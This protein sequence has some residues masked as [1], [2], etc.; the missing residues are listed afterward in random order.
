ML[1]SDIIL[2]TISNSQLVLSDHY[3]NKYGPSSADTSLGGSND[4]VLLGQ[5]IAN[6]EK[7]VKFKRKLNTGDKYDKVVVYGK[8]DMIWA[9][10]KTGDMGFHF[11]DQGQIIVDFVSGTVETDDK[12]LIFYFFI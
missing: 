4:L 6:N 12:L 2:V 3:S 5:S 1:D 10:G 11:D 7:T 8:M 9:R